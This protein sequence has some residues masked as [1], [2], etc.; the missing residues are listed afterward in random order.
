MP[1]PDIVGEYRAEE[2]RFGS[3]LSDT[4]PSNNLS[5]DEWLGQFISGTPRKRRSLITAIESHAEELGALLP[6]FLGK[7]DPDGDD[8]AVGWILQV[9]N[10][11]QANAI[12]EFVASDSNGWFNTYSSVGID[13]APLQQDLLEERFE[14][15]DRFTSSTL[16]KLAG[17]GAESRGYVYFTEVAAMSS[18]D[19][20]TIDRLWVAYSQG[21][22]GFSVQ[23][24]LLNSLNGRYE[25]L[26]PRIGWKTDGIWTRYPNAFNWSIEAPE[27]HMPLINQFTLSYTYKHPFTK[28]YNEH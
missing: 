27:G 16:R 11:H 10:R 21:R 4:S 3:M 8:W 9:L 17:E 5:F 22:F 6:D 7:F 1:M 20:V 18:L 14:E 24:R 19:L 13:F 2:G 12:K 15:A 23:A 25:R 28:I 26:W